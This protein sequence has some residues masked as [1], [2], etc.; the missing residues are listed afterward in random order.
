MNAFPN[1]REFY[2]KPLIPIGESDIQ[3]FLDNDGSSS[4]FTHWLIALEGSEIEKG[5][6]KFHWKIIVFQTTSEGSFDYNSPHYVSLQIPCV[7][8]A[9]EMAKEI[10]SKCKSDCFTINLQHTQI[11]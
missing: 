8:Q 7:H 3:V 1:Y 5:K 2:Q 6:E 10:E 11:V 4:S 9:F